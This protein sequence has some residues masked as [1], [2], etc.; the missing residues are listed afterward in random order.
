MKLSALFFVLLLFL[1]IYSIEV[2]AQPT[3][4]EIVKKADEKMRGEKSSESML[5]MQI[6]RPTWT[7]SVTFKT[8]SLGTDYSMVLIL[9]PA[10]EKGQSFLKRRNEM[11]SW[12]P[13]I[14]RI[15]KLPPSMLAQGWMGS[16]Y[17]NDDLLNQSSIVVDYTHSIVGNEI[18][19]NKDCYKINLVPKEN[20][21]V[22]WGKL[23][24]WISKEDFLQLKAE[25]YD[26]DGYLV[27]TETA[28]EIRNMEG[29]IIP[30]RFVLVPAEKTGNRT[31]ITL[32]A[33]KFN[34]SLAESF[35]SQQNLQKVR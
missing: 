17:T 10:K 30:T 21:P 24:L 35:F 28:S 5:T 16:D 19:L 25:Y 11:W 20:A 2:T 32:N 1:P 13:A 22:V 14:N 33:I 34:V 26:E 8:W 4:T 12:N 23:I 15:I 6:I 29:R 7:R 18:L 31:L 27:K 3:A 9:E